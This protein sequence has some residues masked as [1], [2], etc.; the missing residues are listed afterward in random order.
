[1][2]A[3]QL[4]GGFYTPPE[5]VA[6]CLLRVTTLIGPR[7]ALEI[8]EPSAGDGA[9]VRGAELLNGSFCPE[10]RFT[11][12]ELIATEAAKC[13]AAIQ[14]GHIKGK[15]INDSFFAWAKVQSHLFDALVGNPPFVRYQFVP[16]DQ[17]TDA[18]F[19]F[20]RLGKTLA[21]VS[22]LW[23]PI[24]LVSLRFLRKGGAFAMVLPSELFATKSTGVVRSELIREF[25]SLRVDLY[26]RG[27]FGKILQ[28][29]IVLSGRRAEFLSERRNVE[30]VEHG[31]NGNR[32][33]KH[34]IPDTTATWM[35]YLLTEREL[36]AYA[37][38]CELSEMKRLSEVAQI[39]VS[40]VT[41]ANDFFTVDDAT[42]KKF[43]LNRW[44]KPLLARTSDC[45]GLVFEKE[46]HMSARK[47]GKKVWML[48][49]SAELPD[50]MKYALP[51]QYLMQ[52]ES[53]KLHARYKTSIRE[54]W[55]RVPSMR[56]DCLLLSKRAHQFHR[57]LW[58]KS[59]A[60]TTDTIYRGHMKKPY[61]NAG[62]SLVA[63]FHNSATILSSEIEGRTYGG[64][65]LEL[66]PSEVARI[67][68][69]MVDMKRHLSAL[70]R[71]CRESGGQL[72]STDTLI[73]RTDELLC[74]I[75]PSLLPLMNDLFSARIHLRQ[76]RFHGQA[77]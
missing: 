30:F 35:P 59:S 46:D 31:E 50:P 45:P 60:L 64:G 69:P 68:V 28:D 2:S 66:V 16:D 3:D 12:L 67:V 57:L 18:K 17:R 49:F 61:E 70:D 77:D 56:H 55:Y 40:I 48:D 38:S 33:W 29:I 26:P 65:V 39:G 42:L 63:G 25:E 10:S 27:S 41:G 1:M 19:L 11:C 73:N 5:L 44:S 13:R 51:R 58:N 37:T 6:D 4:R 53:M 24:F 75:I 7:R 21:G 62:E 72:D 15:V 76:R 74:K 8:L 52:G 20:N 14:D 23:I 9:F 34:W 36:V 71:L 22:N 43:D 47:T 32:V 54:P